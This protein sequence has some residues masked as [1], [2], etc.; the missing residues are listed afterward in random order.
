MYCLKCGCDTSAGN[1]FCDACLAEM[2]TCPVRTDA[3]IQLPN[4]PAPVVEKTPRKKKQHYADYIRVLR[5]LI[6]WLC[7]V[8]AALTLLVCLLG[9]LLFQQLQSA[10]DAPAIGKNYTTT[11]QSGRP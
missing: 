5:R 1:V 2:A 11:E 9:F 4:R 10:P 3:V 7:V 6:R 8:V